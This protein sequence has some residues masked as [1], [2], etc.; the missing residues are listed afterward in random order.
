MRLL[1]PLHT[2]TTR[3]NSIF[4]QQYKEKRPPPPQSNLRGINVNMVLTYSFQLQLYYL[5]QLIPQEKKTTLFLYSTMTNSPNEAK[6]NLTV[7]DTK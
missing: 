5:Y 6:V 3:F 4:Y 1:I 7:V 2:R